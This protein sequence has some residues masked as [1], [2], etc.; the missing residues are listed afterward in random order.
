MTLYTLET[1]DNLINQYIDKGGQV[2]TIEEGVL[3]YGT[4]I[5]YGKDLKTSV[6]KEI[7]LNEW[8]S[9]HTIRSYNKTPNKYKTFTL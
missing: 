5:L 9:V 8:S 1:V 7:Y 4:L 3:G 2:V 6:V